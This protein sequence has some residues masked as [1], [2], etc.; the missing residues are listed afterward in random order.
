M[1]MGLGL[2]PTGLS[3]DLYQTIAQKAE[4]HGFES[5]WVGEAW[6]T[7]TSTIVSAFLA[8]TQ[9]IHVGTGI[10]SLYLRPP[11][12]TA[13]QAASM[14]LIAPGRARLGIGVSTQNINTMH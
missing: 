13:M 9:R 12:L 4:E 6:G 14:D 10:I 11:T 8:S 1:R 2:P 3:F 5:L 7:E